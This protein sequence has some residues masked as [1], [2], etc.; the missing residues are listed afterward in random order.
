MNQNITNYKLQIGEFYMH[1]YQKDVCIEV[2]SVEPSSKGIWDVTLHYWNLGYTGR[3]WKID[4]KAQ[5]VKIHDSSLDFWHHIDYD[6]LTSP[7]YVSGLP[8]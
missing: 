4:L 7:R 6:L 3:P 1:E 8:R 2:L 5:T